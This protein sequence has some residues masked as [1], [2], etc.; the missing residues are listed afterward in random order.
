MGEVYQATDSKLGRSV[1][2]K[3]IPAAFASD[4]DRLS[5]FRREAQL[6]AS[7]NHPCI[8]HIY[9]LEESGD[10][11]CIVMELVEGETLQA[12]IK[13]GPIPVDEALTI[14]KQI[15]EALEAAHDKGVIHRDL[16]PGN[17]ML[18]SDG[19][20]KVL[21]FGL[22]KA[23]DSHS[24]SATTSNSPTMTRMAATDAGVI[25][26]TAAYMS[27]EQA[28]GRA[29]DKRTD[30]WAFGAVLYEMVTGTSAFGD[31]D[32]SMTLSK[33]L[34]REPDF[35][36]LPPATPKRVSQVLRLCLRKDP[37]QRVSDIRDVRLALEGAFETATPPALAPAP[38]SRARGLA[39]IAVIGFAGALLTAAA[40]WSWGRT[41]SSTGNAHAHIG[42]D[43]GEPACFHYRC[44]HPVPCSFTGR[45]SARIRGHESGSPGRSAGRLLAGSLSRQHRCPRPA[46]N[47]R[48]QAALF[49][50]GWTVGRLFHRRPSSRKSHSQV[51]T[52]SRCWRRSTVP[53]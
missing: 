10:T 20:V 5:R 12:R 34:Q 23:Y 29:L 38:R 43:A 45:N 3:L 25:L 22:A 30:I 16:K 36:A 6:L 28:R 8:A 42:D 18:T 40:L 2:I 52:P 48:R 7:L 4:A 37:K 17:V 47:D 9:G 21:D 35:D 19:A 44:T 14:S 15:C 11:T 50:T 49:L 33:V 53:P 46:G 27:P 39:A 1:A 26:G 24:S 32:V 31:E 51:E 41:C 13:R